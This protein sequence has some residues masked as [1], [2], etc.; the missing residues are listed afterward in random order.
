[1]QGGL[2]CPRRRPVEARTALPGLA[3]EAPLPLPSGHLRPRPSA[4]SIG[5]TGR[6]WLRALVPCS[7]WRRWT[8]SFRALGTWYT[9]PRGEPA[10]GVSSPAGSA[11][12]TGLCAEQ[13]TLSVMAGGAEGPAATPRPA[14]EGPGNRVLRSACHSCP[15][16][17]W[18]ALQPRS[19]E[20]HPSCFQ[21][22]FLP[23]GTGAVVGG[24]WSAPL[25][26]P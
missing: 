20:V 10:S 1:M 5:D 7:P 4:W 13:G 6:M 17:G 3:G 21:P 11:P 9:G 22:I 18:L 12:L 23:G 14:G 2:A 16:R 8:S 19:S 25:S 15:P 24:V 26:L